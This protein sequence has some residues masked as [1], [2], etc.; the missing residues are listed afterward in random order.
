[1]KGRERGVDVVWMDYVLVEYGWGLGVGVH[2]MPPVRIMR[3]ISPNNSLGKMIPGKYAVA[4]AVAVAM[5][6][7]AVTVLIVAIAGAVAILIV[8]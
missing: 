5:L 3:L 4:A 1:M 2:I 8:L 7:V 6:I